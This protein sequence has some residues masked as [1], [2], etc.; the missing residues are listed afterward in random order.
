LRRWLQDELGEEVLGI[1]HGTHLLERLM[2]EF[3][4]VGDFKPGVQE[5]GSMEEAVDRADEDEQAKSLAEHLVC[6]WPNK[7]V[8]LVTVRDAGRFVKTHPLDFPMGV[9]DLYDPD[10]PRKVSVSE[11]VQHLPRYRDGS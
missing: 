9:G 2:F 4:V 7:T 3:G 10:R 1:E 5:S 6:G 8:D 11:W